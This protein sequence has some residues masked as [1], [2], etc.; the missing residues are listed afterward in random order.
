MER[1]KV[2]PKRANL[3]DNFRIEV[4]EPITMMPSC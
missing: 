3:E 4:Q 2:N 1:K